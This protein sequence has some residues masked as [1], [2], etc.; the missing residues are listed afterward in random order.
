ME[1]TYVSEEGENRPEPETAPSTD[2]TTT[3]TGDQKEGEE[4]R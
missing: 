4:E 2:V 1:R 3:N